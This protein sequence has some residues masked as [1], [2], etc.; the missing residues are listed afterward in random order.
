MLATFLGP[1]PPKWPPRPLQ[2]ASKTV[3][4]ASKDG[5]D[6][7]RRPKTRP[8]LPWSPPDLDRW[9]LLINI[10][11]IF[12]R[13][14]IDVLL[15]CESSDHKFLMTLSSETLIFEISLDIENHRFVVAFLWPAY[16]HM[17]IYMCNNDVKID[18]D[19]YRFVIE[20]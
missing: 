8:N 17:C 6:C 14:L 13:L 10:W 20:Y 12:D 2:D 16:I 4:D 5:S 1:R 9:R 7:P 19:V 18:V 3:Q 11:S 15:I